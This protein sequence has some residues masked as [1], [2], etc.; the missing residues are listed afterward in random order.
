M[1]LSLAFVSI[2][3]GYGSIT[4]IAHDHHRQSAIGAL[5]QQSWPEDYDSGARPHGRVLDS[6]GG[7]EAEDYDSPVPEASHARRD[8]IQGRRRRGTTS[9]FTIS[10]HGISLESCVAKTPNSDFSSFLDKRMKPAEEDQTGSQLQGIGKLLALL[11]TSS[12]LRIESLV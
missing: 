7:T 12:L 9:T 6:E 4:A 2:V 1:A 11:V 5:P 3:V 10:I 8:S